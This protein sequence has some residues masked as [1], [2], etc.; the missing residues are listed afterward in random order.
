MSQVLKNDTSIADP[1]YPVPPAFAD[2]ANLNR[3]EYLEKMREAEADPEA[4]WASEG[5]RLNWIKPYT[6]VK[7]TSFDPD[8]FRIRWYE[9]G[10]LNVSENCL[11]RHLETRGDK[12]AIIWES[13]DPALSRTITYR[14][15]HAEVCTFANVL[16]CLG[17]ERGD[18]VTI[19]LPMVPEA[20]VAM[21]ACARIGAIHS[22]VFAGFSPEALAGRI[23]DCDSKVVITADEGVRGGKAVPLKAN[24]DRACKLEGVDVQKV[25][26]IRRTGGAVEMQPA[27]DHYLHDVKVTLPP[28]C[29]AEAMGAEDP[30]F[31]LYTSGSTGKPKKRQQ[32]DSARHDLCQM[33]TDATSLII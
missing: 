17:V 21:L 28:V 7:D 10:V 6:K 33:S 30:L 24:V 2:K 23:I 26:V 9:D 16:K 3:E 14:E 13:D 15:L 20:A 8:D 4:F 1:A 25:L 12:P 11:D 5:R 19:Y 27:R 18:R 22:V 29:P 32:Y 31:I